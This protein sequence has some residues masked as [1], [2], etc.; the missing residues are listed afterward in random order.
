MVA[1]NCQIGEEEKLI[2]SMDIKDQEMLIAWIKMEETGMLNLVP[3]FSSLNIY[4]DAMYHDRGPPQE[5]KNM[6]REVQ[7]FYFKLVSFEVN[8]DFKGRCPRKIEIH[9]YKAQM[10]EFARSIKVK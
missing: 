3:G 8:W 9:R 1:G 4:D 6:E 2:D 5:Y 10:T 7:E